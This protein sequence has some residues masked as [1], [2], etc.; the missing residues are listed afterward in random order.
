MGH[1]RLGSLPKSFRW[2]ELVSLMS[3]EGRSDEIPF[4]DEDVS[5]IVRT[6]LFAADGALRKSIDDPGLR[7]AYYL[8]TQIA[9]ASRYPDWIQ[10]LAKVG[11]ILNPQADATDL[12][13]ALQSA[14]DDHLFTVRASS[15]VASAAQHAAGEAILTIVG[16][17][18]RTLF[19]SSGE[20][21]RIAVRNAS[22]KAGFSVLA[23]TFFASFLA[24]F[25]N[26]YVS[27]ISASETG[28]GSIQQIGDLTHFNDALKVHCRQSAEIVRPFAGE[29]YSKTEYERGI[30]PDNTGGFVAVA[31]GKLRAEL[32]TQ[33]DDS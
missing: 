26:F 7:H 8:L 4:T 21:L 22:T 31:I 19:G 27:R 23:Q 32:R 30:A 29:W 14:V 5:N 1:Q 15:D 9:L 10:R 18:S 33:A 12:V 3:S 28:S 17:R 6:T 13:V 11:V 25:L 24:R 16:P 20:E 2:N